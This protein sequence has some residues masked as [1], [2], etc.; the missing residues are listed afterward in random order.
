MR[1]VLL[2]IYLV[3]AASPALAT[4]ELLRVDAMLFPSQLYSCQLWDGDPVF[5]Y[6]DGQVWKGHGSIGHLSQINRNV[7]IKG[8]CSDGATTLYILY[9]DGQIWVSNMGSGFSLAMD[10]SRD[11]A[12]ATAFGRW[13]NSHYYFVAYDDGQVWG[14][15]GNGGQRLE[16]AERLN[17]LSDVES[18]D[19]HSPSATSVAPNPTA[20]P[21]RVSC[22]LDV[23]G[24]VSVDIIDSSGRI[25]RRLLDGPHPAGEYSLRWDGKDDAGR[26][27]PAGVYFT[28]VATSEGT[29]TGR[30]VLAR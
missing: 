13:N 24:P 27:L 15:D 1:A 21:C 8:F 28:H 6:E 22:R 17:P 12:Q 18:E 16:W 19:R 25:V 9:E 29:T 11:G 23:D 10:A 14:Y 7:R 20:G 4:N 26:E 3:L 5:A 2:T 30:V